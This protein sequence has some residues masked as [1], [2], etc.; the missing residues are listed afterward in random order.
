MKLSKTKF[1]LTYFFLILLMVLSMFSTKS[2]ASSETKIYLEVSGQDL[3][4]MD[5]SLGLWKID[6]IFSDDNAKI[7]FIKDANKKEEK[8]LDS[9]YKEFFDLSSFDIV[10]ENQKTYLVFDSKS[11]LDGS[12]YVRSYFK[13]K[14]DESF[15]KL[16]YSFL[17]DLPSSESKIYPKKDIPDYP[18][19]DHEKPSKGSKKF[20]KVDSTDN[21]IRLEGAEFNLYKTDG[22]L[23]IKTLRSG[24]DGSFEVNNLDYGKYYLREVKAPKG[25]IL[26]GDKIEFSINQND[27]DEV[28]ETRIIENKPGTPDNDKKI[29][30]PKTGDITIILMILM[31]FVLIVFGLKFIFEKDANSEAK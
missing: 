7:D 23:F 22:N 19:K 9:M 21:D 1:K 20:I 5:F 17:L 6:Q 8:V 4:N 30:V 27:Q 11:L 25:Y 12:Y 24:K 15:N 28:V 10:E 2:Y 26:S 14:Q 31:G 29:D 16:E 18:D 3:E 13:D